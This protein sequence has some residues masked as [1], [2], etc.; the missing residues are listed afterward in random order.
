MDGESPYAGMVQ[1]SDANFYGTTSTG[2]A[3][4]NGGTIFEITPGGMLTTLYNFCSLIVNGVCTD[5]GDPSLVNSSEAEI[6]A[7]IGCR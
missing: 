3:N 1:G 6:V 7:Q 2:G 4:G 5:G